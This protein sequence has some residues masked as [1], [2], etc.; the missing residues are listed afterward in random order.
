MLAIVTRN[1]RRVGGQGKRAVLVGGVCRV[2]SVCAIKYVHA[3]A[4]VP[5]D[6]PVDVI[7]KFGVPWDRYRYMTARRDPIQRIDIHSGIMG[8]G[9]RLGIIVEERLQPG[10][11]ILNPSLNHRKDGGWSIVIKRN[12]L[13]ACLR[14]AHRWRYLCVGGSGEANKPKQD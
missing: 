2:Q 7:G 5:V 14:R 8:F 1:D 9:I 13:A 11:G 12:D 3:T 4:I 6:I 10:I